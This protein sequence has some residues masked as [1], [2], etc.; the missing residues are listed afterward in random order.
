MEN[1]LLAF[2]HQHTIDETLFLNKLNNYFYLSFRQVAEITYNN[3]VLKTAQIAIFLLH[4]AFF[5]IY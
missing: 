1:H 5:K 3:Y 4:A 2:V